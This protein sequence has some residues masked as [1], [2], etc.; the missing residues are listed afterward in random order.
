MVEILKK[1]VMIKSKNGIPFA[2]ASVREAKR[3]IDLQI[4]VAISFFKK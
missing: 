1:G 2:A 4:A 3:L